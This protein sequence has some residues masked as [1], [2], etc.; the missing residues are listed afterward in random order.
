MIYVDDNDDKKT[1]IKKWWCRDW[2]KEISLEKVNTAKLEPIWNKLTTQS[3]RTKS[4]AKLEPKRRQINHTKSKKP[5][6]S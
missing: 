6:Q 5:S 3:L 4:R 2:G 1:R